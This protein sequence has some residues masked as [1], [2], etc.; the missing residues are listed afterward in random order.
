MQGRWAI[1]MAWGNR[2]KLRLARTAIKNDHRKND[3][4][5]NSPEELGDGSNPHRRRKRLDIGGI[6]AKESTV[7]LGVAATIV[8]DLGV[9]VTGV[10]P[11]GEIFAP[12]IVGPDQKSTALEAIVR[13]LAGADHLGE[14]A[15]TLHPGGPFWIVD[16]E[17]RIV[18]LS[19]MTLLPSLS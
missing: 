2:R 18:D 7:D 9:F 1:V 4:N 12:T 14:D 15:L 5:S 16:C 6:A 17:L 10:Q 19:S 8:V 11:G 13:D 3:L